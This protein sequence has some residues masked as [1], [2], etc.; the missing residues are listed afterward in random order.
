MSMYH[1]QKNFTSESI[2][3]LKATYLLRGVVWWRLVFE[4]AIPNP[5]LLQKFSFLALLLWLFPPTMVLRIKAV[6]VAIILRV[7]LLLPVVR[8]KLDQGV[9]KENSA[10]DRNGH[11]H[12]VLA[13]PARRE[14]VSRLVHQPPYG[15]HQRIVGLEHLVPY[16]VKRVGECGPRHARRC[17][18]GGRSEQPVPI[19]GRRGGIL[20][21]RQFLFHEI[22]D[23]DGGTIFRYGFQYPRARPVPQPT[24]SVVLVDVPDRCHR[25]GEPRFRVLQ[26]D[27]GPNDRLVDALD[28]RADHEGRNHRRPELVYPCLSHLVAADVGPPEDGGPGPGHP[29][30]HPHHT[31]VGRGK[32]V[33][34]GRDGRRD[35]PQQ[36]VSDEADG[37]ASPAADA[38]SRGHGKAAL[39]HGRS[40][41]EGIVDE[42]RCRGRREVFPW[43]VLRGRSPSHCFCFCCLFL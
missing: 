4:K 36:G 22:L 14:S 12:Q 6:V 25:V 3:L 42:S 13:H 7:V 19:V 21:G 32:G 15:R 18:L 28:H 39:G 43:M 40:P 29:G 41:P 34:V 11:R 23:Q 24:Q 1:M 35:A 33:D 5:F 38:G 9:R 20:D 16:D 10:P 31:L 8:R 27:A 17:A 26:R 2:D 37:P 30:D